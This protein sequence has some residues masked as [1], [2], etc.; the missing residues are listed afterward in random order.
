MAVTVWKIFENATE[1][2]GAHLIAGERGLNRLVDWVHIVEDQETALFLRGGEVVFTAGLMNHDNHWLK[3]FVI[4]LYSMGVSA[5]VVNH[6]PHIESVPKEVIDYCNEVE[7]PLYVI[8]WK[9][10]MVDMTRCFCQK[11]FEDMKQ[12]TSVASLIKNLIFH[13]GNREDVV[14]SL[15]RSGFSRNCFYNVLSIHIDLPMESSAYE[16][17]DKQIRKAAEYLA[18][19]GKHHMIPFHYRTKD[20]LIIGMRERGATDDFI[21]QLLEKIAK[22][23][24]MKY[25]SIGVGQESEGFHE[26]DKNFTRTFRLSCLARRRKRE[27]LYYKDSDIEKLLIAINDREVLHSYYDK[28]LKRLRDYDRDNDTDLTEFFKTYL[29]CNC[30]PQL[31]SDTL[32]IHRN[33]VSNYLHRIMDILEISELNQETLTGLYLAYRI[34]EILD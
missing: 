12:Q 31:V 11:I 6:G 1:Q 28:T 8:P 18:K 5:F 14:T 27:V 7:L 16:E 30:K 34:G 25:C 19:A 17:A 29:D 33:T 15:V 26:L 24:L 2:Y 9:T 21:R 23:D 22:L 13:V 4:K 20:I 32:Y 10:R 3:D